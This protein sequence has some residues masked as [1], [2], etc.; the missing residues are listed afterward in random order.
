MKRLFHIALSVLS[1]LFLSACDSG[2]GPVAGTDSTLMEFGQ[3]EH[4]R[5]VLALQF[6]SVGCSGCPAM[7]EAVKTVQNE[8]SGVLIPVAFHADYGN[9][10][11]PM[12]VSSVIPFMRQYSIETLPH[13][14]FNFHKT[15]EDVLADKYSVAAAMRRE[16][17]RESVPCGVALDTE[18]DELSGTIKVS[19]S[20]ATNVESRFRYHVFLVEDGIKGI[21]YG[22]SDTQ[23]YTHDNVVRRMVSSDIYG[24]NINDRRPVPAGYQVTAIER[25]PVEKGWNLANLRVVAAAMITEDDGYT[26]VCANANECGLGKKAEYYQ[27]PSIYEKHIAV[28]EF[29]GTW[30][31]FCP[32]GYSNA[33]FVIT[34]NPDY[35][36]KVHVMAFHS[37]E[38]GE[39]PMALEA[40]DQIRRYYKF[41]A[42]GFPAYL[43]DMR[44]SGP[45]VGETYEQ[46]EAFRQ[47]L[48]KIYN[49][50]AVSCGLALSSVVQGNE[51]D[52]EVKLTSERNGAYRIAV[53]VV[54]DG[55]I[56]PQNDASVYNDSY[57]HDH[58]VR[59]VVTSSFTGESLGT[60]NENIEVTRMYKVSLD[61]AWN[62]EKTYIYALAV[63]SEGHVDN[64][65]FCQIDGGQASYTL[66]K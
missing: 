33:S 64:M 62:L 12:D 47:S 48:S 61:S 50:N 21:Q 10:D 24:K 39:D 66:L 17:A 55:I 5:K 4:T 63:N 6:T 36:D 44:E 54:E 9:V 45:L 3:M 8:N 58:V 60:V 56:A 31:A 49:N 35:S 19:V 41:E 20:I 14:V 29:T 2:E 15:S 53:F 1:A 65:N 22:A 25:I 7:S 27:T 40:T 23:N 43:I 51:A 46:K 13:V 59:K 28:W 42:L 32:Q 16:L 38:Q 34:R 18:Y 57:Q 30:C 52:V 37:A 11:D 26:W